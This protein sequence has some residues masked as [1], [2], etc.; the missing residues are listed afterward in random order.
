MKTWNFTSLV[1]KVASIEIS[2][3]CSHV[4]IDLNWAGLWI[5]MVNGA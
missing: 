5:P 2:S 1:P 4:S 3:L